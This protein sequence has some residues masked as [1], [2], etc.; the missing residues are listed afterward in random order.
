MPLTIDHVLLTRFNL[1]SPGVE[2]LVRAKEGWLR[3]RQSLFERYCLPSVRAQVQRSFHWIIYLDVQSPDWLKNRITELSHDGLFVPIYREE[4][5]RDDLLK[6]IRAVTGAAGDVLLTTNL[7]NDDAVAVDFVARLQKG[8]AGTARRALYLTNGL[9]MQT[10]ALYRHRDVSNAFCSV[11]ESWNA[12]VTCWSDWHNRLE[13]SMPATR[14]HGAP[15][16][17]QVVHGGNVSNRV[18]GVRVRPDRYTALFP[19]VVA[20]M[21]QPRS[22]DLWM[23]QLVRSRVRLLRDGARAVAKRTILQVGG[24]AGLDRIKVLVAG[25]TR[26]GG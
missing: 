16:W 24:K 19:S 9:I 17:L 14:L 5:P 3:N 7:D 18:R 25:R 26:A 2:S 8:V 12:P 23:D 10:D 1:P 6:D 21:P 4:V 13:Y 20:T 15:G 22:R 11:A